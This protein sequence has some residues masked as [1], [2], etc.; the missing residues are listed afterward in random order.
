MQ[1]ADLLDLSLEGR[2][3]AV[4]LEYERDGDAIARLTF[5]ELQRRTNRLAR[6]LTSHG[7]SRGDRIAFFLPNGVGF[8]ELFIACLKLGAIVVP[9]NILYREREVAHILRDSDPRLVATTPELSRILEGEAAGWNVVNVHELIRTAEDADDARFRS[10]IDGDDP[11]AIVYT[12]GTTGQSKGAVLSHNVFAFNTV[13]LLTCWQITSEDRYLAVLPLF[14]VHGLGN[15]VLSWLASGCLMRLAARFEI[16]RAKELFESFHPTLFFGVPTVYV[17]LLEL[18]EDLCREIGRRARLFVSGS[19]PLPAPVL[20]SFK[21]K[22]GHTILERYGMSET[23][24]NIGNPYQGE[25]RAGSVGFPFPGV[26]VRLLDDELNPVPAGTVGEVFV[27]GGNVFSGY[28]RRPE[29]TRE[30]FVDGWFRTGD[31]AERSE[32]GYYTMRGRRTDLIISGGFNIYPQEIE[33]L[34]LENQAVREVAVCGVPDERRGEI[35]VAY[36]VADE[37]FDEEALR[38]WCSQKLASFKVPRAFVRVESLPRTALGKVQ[39]KLLPS[40]TTK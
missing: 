35:P 34:L 2:P 37:P 13:N 29:A 4:A 22:F 14:H 16:A 11:A 28:W 30:A 39:K 21:E 20:D 6:T 8:I 26:S 12:S 17:R 23:L 5:G 7:I 1:L 38:E 24:M 18:D 25:R 9:I 10:H 32:D 27:R 19:A 40:L 3:S 31:L 33:D 15:G 36:V